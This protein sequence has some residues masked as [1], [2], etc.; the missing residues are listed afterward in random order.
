MTVVAVDVPCVV[1]S[2][3]GLLFDRR[4]AGWDVTVLLDG[5][6]VTSAR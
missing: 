5:V 3:G 4:L 6:C 2:I 1:S